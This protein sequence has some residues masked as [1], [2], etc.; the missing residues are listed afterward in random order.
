M[1]ENSLT[2]WSLDVKLQRFWVKTLGATLMPGSIRL[3]GGDANGS[4]RETQNIHSSGSDAV[5]RVPQL[6]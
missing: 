4:S 1:S 2:V 3:A 6:S 5:H